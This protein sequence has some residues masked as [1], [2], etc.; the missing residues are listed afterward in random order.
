MTEIELR[1]AL[2]QARELKNSIEL[3]LGNT[4]PPGIAVRMLREPRICDEVPDCTCVFVD[5]VSFTAFSATK[6]SEP[7]SLPLLFTLCLLQAASEVVA[8]LDSLFTAFDEAVLGVGVC[9]IK[10]IGDGYFFAAGVPELQEDH[11]ARAARAALRLLALIEPHN[12]LHDTSFSARIGLCSGPAVAGVVG[13][14]RF[15]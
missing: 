1:V 2:A 10:T 12:R 6:V 11:A 3:L 9:K 4:L 13:S 14:I 5:L 7:N 8:N 15:Q